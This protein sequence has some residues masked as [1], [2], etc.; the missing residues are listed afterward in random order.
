[1][2]KR[3]KVAVISK[4]Q[5]LHKDEEALPLLRDLGMFL[6]KNE[7]TVFT[8]FA[9]ALAYFKEA[10]LVNSDSMISL[11]PACSKEEHETIFRYSSLSEEIILYTG[12]G[13]ELTILTILRSSDLII[14][15]D[16][17]ALLEVKSMKDE[18]M[19]KE[20]LLLS[21]KMMGPLESIVSSFG[22]A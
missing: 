18:V 16:D 5:T 19:K 1:M 15:L 17:G 6:A 3:M 7:A 14:C 8:H 21:G 12:L 9:P 4:N 2:K 20:V 11:S 10:F 13:K 22:K